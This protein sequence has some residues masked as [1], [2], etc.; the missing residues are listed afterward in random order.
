MMNKILSTLYLLVG[1]FITLSAIG[2]SFGGVH[3]V[4]DAFVISQIT[5]PITNVIITIWHFAGLGMVLFG[6]IIF[7]HWFRI[8]RCEK[9]NLL[10]PFTISIFYISHGAIVIPIQRDPYIAV[11]LDLSGLLF[12]YTVAIRTHHLG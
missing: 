5:K 4:I 3:Q 1:L 8:Q 9:V 10:G 7:W 6:L 2:H 12:N 11:F